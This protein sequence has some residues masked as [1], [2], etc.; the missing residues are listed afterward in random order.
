MLKR[1]RLRKAQAREWLQHIFD[2]VS[3]RNKGRKKK[4]RFTMKKKEENF[5]KYLVWLL[6][7]VPLFDQEGVLSRTSDM[8]V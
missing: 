2:V 4:E 7:N 3:H 8:L 5:W 1:N 6:K